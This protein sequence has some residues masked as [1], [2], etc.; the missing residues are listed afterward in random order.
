VPGWET[1]QS[2]K[3]NL[4][5]VS[6]AHGVQNTQQMIALMLHYFGMKAIGDAVDGI[7]H[8]HQSLCI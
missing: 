2:C 5:K 7:D 8:I 3:P 4:A 6:H 1:T